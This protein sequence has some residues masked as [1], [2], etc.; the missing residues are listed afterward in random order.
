MSSC[1]KK[2]DEVTELLLKNEAKSDIKDYNQSLP[3]NIAES[4]AK[5]QFRGE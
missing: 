4:E 2:L 3:L 1:I 5:L